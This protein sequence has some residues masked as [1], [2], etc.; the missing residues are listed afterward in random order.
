M[1]SKSKLNPNKQVITN[2]I[3]VRNKIR[4]K[5]QKIEYDK[6]VRD[7]VIAD[8]LKPL[9][10]PLE[11]LVDKQN[12]EKLIKV[13]NEKKSRTKFKPKKMRKSL[14]STRLSTISNTFNE[15]SGSDDD[16]AQVSE[17][18]LTI[19]QKPSTSS[20]LNRYLSD[21]SF[22]S[23]IETDNEAIS[24]QSE[25]VG[26]FFRQHGSLIGKCTYGAVQNSGGDFTI[27]NFPLEI[28]ANKL[29][30]GEKEYE[31]TS[32]LMNLLFLKEPDSSE[33]NEQDKENYREILLETSVHKLNYD[34]NSRTRGNSSKKYKN[35][36]GPLSRDTPNKAIQ[37]KGNNQK[38]TLMQLPI[39]KFNYV[40]Y[41]NL[42][43]LVERLK[44]L[45]ANSISG[46]ASHVNEIN[47]IVEELR[48]SRVI[49]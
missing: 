15:S 41:D 42:N 8:N 38:T 3:D 39:G 43:E 37:G 17:N 40:Y 16:E 11:Q 46:N 49:Q 6:I 31:A 12:K 7:K 36:V 2:I 29:K 4:K 23:L 30:I 1:N 18:D 33:I 34:P 27:G 20:K 5:L 13:D 44:I 19:I 22:H 26:N 24:E 14:E 25:I 9:I 47:S 10:S 32:G 45:Y 28:K 21:D 35:F 48:E